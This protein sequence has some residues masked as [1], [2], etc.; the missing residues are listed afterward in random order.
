[1]A[2]L[3]IAPAVLARAQKPSAS[4]A[5]D[6]TLIAAFAKSPYIYVSPLLA[7]GVESTCH[8]E[9]WFGW[10]GGAAV[11]ITA[12]TT[13]KARSLARGLTQARLWVGDHGRWKQMLGRDES[14]RAA[15]SCLARAEQS[16]DPKL[17]DELL[18]LYDQKYPKEIANW[19]EK[20]RAGFGDGSRVLIRYA[21]EAPPRGTGAART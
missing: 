17:L 3:A 12:S 10:L 21:P 16:K 1:M 7:S 20:M 9:V 2:G 4:D 13:W 15:P 14:F 19:R 8:G 6:P 18:A 5:L 11:V